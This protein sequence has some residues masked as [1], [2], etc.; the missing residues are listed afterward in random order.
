MSAAPLSHAGPRVR[1]R[2]GSRLGACCCRPAAASVLDTFDL[3][4]ARPAAA[5]ALRAQVRVSRT[6]RRHRPRQRPN[7]GAHRPAGSGDAGGREMAGSS[8]ADRS[9]ATDPDVRERR[10]RCVRS[11]AARRRRRTTSSTS[12]FEGSNSTPLNRAS[13]S[14]SPPRSSPSAAAASSRRRSSPPRRRSLRPAGAAVSAAMDGALSSVMT[15]IVAF[16]SARL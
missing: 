5:R 8:A 15:R 1:A 4:A 16:V 7:S 14:I 10:S 2:R 12:T 13:K 9:V 3:N 6:D 11:A